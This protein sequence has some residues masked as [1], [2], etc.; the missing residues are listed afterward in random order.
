[1]PRS[2]TPA[3]SLLKQGIYLLQLQPSRSERPHYRDQQQYLVP[4]A[5]GST[6][7]QTLP[8]GTLF[9]PHLKTSQAGQRQ[10]SGSSTAAIIECLKIPASERRKYVNRY[11]SRIGVAATSGSTK[12]P[13]IVTAFD[14]ASL[15]KFGE[16]GK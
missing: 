3:L 12:C 6:T 16:G 13:V 2:A 8:K 14:V 4:N 7:V 1:M 10:R 5:G 15:G 9:P 11:D